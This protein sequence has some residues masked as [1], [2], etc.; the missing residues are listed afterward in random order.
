MK[1]NRSAFA[2]AI[3][4]FFCFTVS[5][6]CQ[7][8]DFTTTNIGV[9]NGPATVVAVDINNNGKPGLVTTDFGFRFG[10]G[11]VTGGGSGT[12]LSVLTN[13]GF[14]NLS[15]GQQ[16]RLAMSR[17][18]LAVADVNG[19]G[20]ADLICANVGDNS[21]TVLTNNRV[22]SF[23]FSKTLS[24]GGIPSFVVAADLDGDGS[25]DLDLRELLQRYA[26]RVPQ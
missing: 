15:L 6:L 9:G 21:L 1:K 13:D 23:S 4:A 17:A 3:G 2:L 18:S 7:Q 11:F 16:F 14:G 12:T 24:V 19:D 10:G 8:L 20:F 25:I 22:G 5:V 26:G